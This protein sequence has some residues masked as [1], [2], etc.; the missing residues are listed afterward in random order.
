MLGFGAAKPVA[1][2]AEDVVGSPATK[3]YDFVGS[4]FFDNY[5]K[6]NGLLSGEI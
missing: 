2:H 4:G 1:G 5:R 6:L 3:I